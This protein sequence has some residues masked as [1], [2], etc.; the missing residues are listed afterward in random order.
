M[1]ADELF[2]LR[3]VLIWSLVATAA[4]TTILQGSQGLGLSRM[5]LPFLLGTIF[6]GD[7]R[8]AHVIGFGLYVVGGWA[9]AGVY[10]LLFHVTGETASWW[11]GAAL[12]LLHG[13]FLLAVVL[14]LLPYMHPRMASEHEGPSVTRRLEPPGHFG[15]NYGRRTALVTLLGQLVYGAI[16]GAA[17]SVH[18]G[19]RW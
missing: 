17:Y 12:G 14:P 1:S 11:L 9:F 18:L 5:S 8:R 15:L 7:R 2:H 16:L 3:N 13:L 19:G 4:M 10:Y 6:S